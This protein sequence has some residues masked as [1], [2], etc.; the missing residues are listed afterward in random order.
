MRS[1]KGMSSKQR[2]ASFAKK[3]AVGGAPPAPSFG[4]SGPR[5]PALK[6]PK[7]NA[8]RPSRYGQ[9]QASDDPAPVSSFGML[10][11][12]KNVASGVPGVPNLSN[13]NRK[14]TNR[15]GF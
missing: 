7:A 1:L 8:S 9:G 14:S 13:T 5:G 3:N 4:S 11:T 15:F 12:K 2:S 10:P 6:A